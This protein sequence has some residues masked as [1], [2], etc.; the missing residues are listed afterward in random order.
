MNMFGN[1]GEVHEYFRNPENFEVDPQS[2]QVNVF[3][4]SISKKDFKPVKESLILSLEK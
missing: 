2:A 3:V 4:Y 1:I